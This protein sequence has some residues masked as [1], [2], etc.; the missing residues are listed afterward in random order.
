MQIFNDFLKF[1]QGKSMERLEQAK[2]EM[3]TLVSTFTKTI[4]PAVIQHGR[5]NTKLKLPSD[6]ELNESGKFYT[7]TYNTNQPSRQGGAL[8]PP[9]RQNL[10]TTACKIVLFFKVVGHPL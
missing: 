9:F 4:V 7:C 6:D 5:M 1:S 3:A 8:A 2:T 10:Q